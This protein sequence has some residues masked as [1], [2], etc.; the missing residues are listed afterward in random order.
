MRSDNDFVEG[1]TVPLEIYWHIVQRA[2]DADR[3]H[4]YN[5]YIRLCKVTHGFF[6]LDINKI[7]AKIL[8]DHILKGEKAEALRL[9][10]MNP[11]LLMIEAEGMDYALGCGNSRRVIRKT[12]LLAMIGTG[13]VDMLR[14][15]LQVQHGQTCAHIDKV[16]GGYEVAIRGFEEFFTTLKETPAYDFMPLVEATNKV[17]FINDEFDKETENVFLKFMADFKPKLITAGPHFDLNILL[18]AMTVYNTNC[19]AA[20]W[21]N[22]QRTVFLYGAIGYLQLLVSTCDAQAICAGLDE[23]LMSNFSIKR[24]LNFFTGIFQSSYFISHE[25]IIDEGVFG[26][27][28]PIFGPFIGFEQRLEKYCKAKTTALMDLHRELVERCKPTKTLGMD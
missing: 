24:S 4:F 25:A 22:R 2:N 12:P 21:Q 1:L 20:H 27:L 14:A 7:G 8:L 17:S 19:Y 26:N 3:L 16:R 15:V 18:A 5:S 6:K 11:E 13:D 10:A 28:R 9:I 23:V